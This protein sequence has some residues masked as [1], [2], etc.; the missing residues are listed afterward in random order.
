MHVF[1]VNRCKPFFERVTHVRKHIHV[2]YVKDNYRI[3]LHIK[4]TKVTS[5]HDVDTT[6]GLATVC[7]DV[8]L[9]LLVQEPGHGIEMDCGYVFS[10]PEL[11]RMLF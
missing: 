1:N 5:L 9:F 6:K 11:E 2:I 3:Q 7:F 10:N 8:D 4:R